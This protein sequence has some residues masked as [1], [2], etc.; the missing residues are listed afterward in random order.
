MPDPGAAIGGAVSLIGANEQADAARDAADAQERAAQANIQLQREQYQQTREDIRPWR[1]TGGAALNELSLR[2]LGRQTSFQ[3]GQP[4]P[5]PN[6][7]MAR[8]LASTGQTSGAPGEFLRPYDRRAPGFRPFTEAAPRPEDIGND[9]G[10]QFR[11][12]EGLKAL[13]RSASARGGLLSGGTLKGLTKYAQGVASDEFQNAYSRFNDRYSRFR[14]ER[15]DEQDEYNTGF[16]R[17]Q[18]DIGNRFNRL[19]SLAGIGQTASQQLQRAGEFFSTSASR[20]NSEAGNA[21]ASGAIGVGNAW[22]GA[23]SNIGNLFMRRGTGSGS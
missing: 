3:P 10:Y 4:P 21:R 23:L 9:P 2:T 8:A 18:T 7:P 20:E 17:Y 6:H 11:M 5:D 16:N 1:E 22:S 15:V 19:S 12:A 14:A 13:E